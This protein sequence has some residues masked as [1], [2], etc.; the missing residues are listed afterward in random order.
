ML[1]AQPSQTTELDTTPSPQVKI[2]KLAPHQRGQLLALE[3]E[4][5]TRT[6]KPPRRRT[7]LEKER[8]NEPQ[9]EWGKLMQ[10][11]QSIIR[12]R[13][14]ETI[15]YRAFETY[16]KKKVQILESLLQDPNCLCAIAALVIPRKLYAESGVPNTSLSF[17]L[18]T[19][20]NV[21]DDNPLS[22]C[23][24]RSEL[25]TIMMQHLKDPAFED[26]DATDDELIDYGLKPSEIHHLILQLIRELLIIDPEDYDENSQAQ[27]Y[28]ERIIGYLMSLSISPEALYAIMEKGDASTPHI[29]LAQERIAAIGEMKAKFIETHLYQ[30]C[31]T[32][33]YYV[34]R[35]SRAKDCIQCGTLGLARSVDRYDYRAGKPFWQFCW[36]SIAQ[37]MERNLNT[38]DNEIV[39]PAHVEAKI[40]LIKKATRLALTIYG[41]SQHTTI[42]KVLLE[43][44]EK[45]MSI[46]EIIEAQKIKTLQSTKSSNKKGRSN[47]EESDYRA[48]EDTLAMATMDT[49]ESILIERESSQGDN[50]E[51]VLSQVE[52]KEREK[53]ILRYRFIDGLTLEQIGEKFDLTRERI[54]QIE[55]KAK[56]KIREQYTPEKRNNDF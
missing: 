56:R 39:I 46:E 27:K 48:L 50:F 37:A 30:V 36:N 47:G 22:L 8:N 23:D 2:K 53:T 54:R 43:H 44:F 31:F 3:I 16:E 18:S 10:F 35:G 14:H 12:G 34:S 38:I 5:E 40:K 19:L 1:E 13:M 17:Y 42:Q 33:Q 51:V 24:D 49:P 7:N 55:A 21:S 29:Q 11:W 32:A 20:I 28:R 25:L 26:L 6:D 45:E 15:A 41:N 9:T 4:E 52:L